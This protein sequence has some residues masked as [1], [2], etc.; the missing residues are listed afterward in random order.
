MLFAILLMRVMMFTVSKACEK[1]I[2]MSVW[3]YFLVESLSYWVYYGV[4]CCGGGIFCFEAVLMLA[5]WDM[6]FDDGMY[7]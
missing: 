6:R 3:W 7:G 5:L 4:K 2:A 1:S